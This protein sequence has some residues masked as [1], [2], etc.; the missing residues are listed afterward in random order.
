MVPAP[1][2][3]GVDLVIPC[4]H[5]DQ[6]NNTLELTA[7]SQT[8]TLPTPQSVNRVQ[9]VTV[10]GVSRSPLEDCH[11]SLT[12]ATS[13]VIDA[14]PNLTTINPSQSQPN[15]SPISGSVSD[16]EVDRKVLLDESTANPTVT[17]SEGDCN[18]ARAELVTQSQTA[19]N[20]GDHNVDRK[21]VV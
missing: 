12:N 18:V 14:N 6:N 11:V 19:N 5:S 2:E 10:N 21:S 8:S 13:D 1:T 3:E 17:N 15:S 20:F 7:P 9:G 16:S 4:P